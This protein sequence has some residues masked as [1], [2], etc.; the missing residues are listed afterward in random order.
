MNIEQVYVKEVYEEI[1]DHFDKTRAYIWYG[2]K[3]F[4]LSIP[5]NSLILDSGC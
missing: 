4:L 3:Q 1:A 2:I 5:H